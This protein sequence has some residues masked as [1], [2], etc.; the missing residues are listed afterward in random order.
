MATYGYVRVSTV[1]QNLDRQ[2]AKMEGLGIP[3]GNVFVDKASGKNLDRAGYQKLVSTIQPGD[4]LVID[5]LDRLGRDYDAVTN[6]WRRLTREMGVSIRCLDLE[7]FDSAKFAD[8]G[9]LGICLE[10][11]L[12][13][14]L[15]YVAQTERKKMLQRQA[16][17]IEAARKAGKH[18]G[19]KPA[20]VDE[21]MLAQLVAQ[22]QAGEMSTRRAAEL[23]GVSAR[24]YR[25]RRD[26]LLAG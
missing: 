17:G 16:E 15:S 3:A 26:A 9:D 18:L 22:E 6:E 8:M 14:L 20:D 13:S 25:R 10:D 2:L 24:T 5:S 23:L 1:E 19:R 4:A 11:M 21:A 7:F 12:L